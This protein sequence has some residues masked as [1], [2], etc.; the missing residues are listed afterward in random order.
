MIITKTPFRFSMFGG[1]TDYADWYK[2]HGATII[3][4]ALDYHCYINFRALPSFFPHKSKAVYSQIETVNNNADFRH[5]SIRE[6]L[7]Y[8]GIRHGVELHHDSDIPA[9]TGI[10]SSSSFTVGLL[11]A[12]HIHKKQKLSQRQL[13]EMAIHIERELIGEHVGVQDQTMA[14]FGGFRKLVIDKA[15]KLQ[16]TPLPISDDYISFLEQNILFGF[17]GKTRLSQTYSE[18]IVDQIKQ[19]SLDECLHQMHS[20]AIE[21]LG[22]FEAECDLDELGQLLHENWQLKCAIPNGGVSEDFRAFYESARSIGVIG[23]KMMGAGGGGAFYFIA[24]ANKHQKIK[25]QLPN[26]KTWLPMRFCDH[27][28]QVIFKG[29]ENV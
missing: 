19:R 17:T 6:C 20:L 10:G 15:G 1:G 3:A 27:G 18:K 26:I 14:A 7:K 13:A 28:A 4:A 21:A 29:H 9:K 5:P 12:I 8:T 24:P 22:R 2:N 16:V 23:G 11:R 25:E